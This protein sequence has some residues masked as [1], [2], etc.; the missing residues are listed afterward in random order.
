MTNISPAHMARFKNLNELRDD[1]LWLAS[2][3]KTVLYSADNDLIRKQL[4]RKKGAHG[5]GL[6]HGTVRFGQINRARSGALQA[7]L[8][9]GRER[10]VVKTQI[11]APHGLGALLAA[12][13]VAD[14]LE[15]PLKKIATALQKVPAVKGR[16]RLLPAVNNAQ[17]IDDTYNS[18]PAAVMAGLDTLMELPAHRHIAVL[19]SMNELGD[20]SAALHREVAE[21]A[22]SK[23]LDMLITV[24]REAAAYIMPTA[25]EAGMEKGQ[26]KQF[27]TPYEAGHY[28]KKL[29][30]PKDI[31]FVKGSQNGVFT[32]ET[33]RILLSPDLLASEELVRQSKGWKKLKKK[34][35]GL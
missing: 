15:Y 4:E 19:G 23:K 32:E 31:I 9:M 33:S 28:L 20:H 34:N 16:M 27:K 11:I 3:A 14:Q 18:S 24:G 21:Y 29:V 22:A 1:T 7:E 26:V 25:I 2:Q 6:K 30:G 10:A 12:A 8:T 13:S 17:L 35:F 5:Y